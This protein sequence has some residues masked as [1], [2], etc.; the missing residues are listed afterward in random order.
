[1]VTPAI[2]QCLRDSISASDLAACTAAALVS[3][4]AAGLQI[5][6][7]LT[8][9]AVAVA[10]ASSL[11]NFDALETALSSTFGTRSQ[12]TVP[13]PKRGAVSPGA[14]LFCVGTPPGEEE[15]IS[16]EEAVSEKEEEEQ[17]EDLGEQTIVDG[18][19]SSIEVLRSA[20]QTKVVYV[21]VFREGRAFIMSVISRSVEY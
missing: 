20:M 16:D 21:F 15:G 17:E 10:A 11:A 13:T 1:M 19:R 5:A 7:G 9:A 12:S 2:A 6:T 8:N 4:N 14:A 18:L 3:K